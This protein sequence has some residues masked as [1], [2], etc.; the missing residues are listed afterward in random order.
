MAP[1]PIGGAGEG[2][3]SASL[4]AA[5][6]R[7]GQTKQQKWRPLKGLTLKARIAHAALASRVSS[8][9]G[10]LV[11]MATLLDLTQ[12]DA[13]T[14]GTAAT[15]LKALQMRLFLCDCMFG[16]YRW[17]IFRK[18]ISTAEG[19]QP[20]TWLHVPG[21][22]VF[23]V[24]ALHGAAALF[25]A[26]SQQQTGLQSGLSDNL[27]LIQSQYIYIHSGMKTTYCFSLK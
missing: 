12:G 17:P 7:K 16:L 6:P 5:A 2:T 9:P 8:G 24:A 22:R 27:P 3:G 19:E 23:A 13:C 15:W 25:I 1:S 26:R 10:P 14:G 20:A 11:P 21:K 4:D 18:S